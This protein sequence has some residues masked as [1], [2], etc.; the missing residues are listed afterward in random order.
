MDR[1]NNICKQNGLPL[2]GV[3]GLRHSFASLAKHLG[4]PEKLTMQ[5]G[6]WSDYQTM[7]KIYTHISQNDANYYKNAM[8]DFYNANKNAN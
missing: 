2:I 1:V 7:H 8:S 4:M 5:I 3:H 6:G